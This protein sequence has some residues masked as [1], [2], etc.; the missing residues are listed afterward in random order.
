MPND[1]FDDDLDFAG[2]EGMA[3]LRKALEKANKRISELE[4]ENTTFH[5]KAREKT[6]A[7]ALATLGVN[8]K[9]AALVPADISVDG[10]AEW[11]KEYGFVAPPSGDSNETGFFSEDEQTNMKRIEGATEKAGGTPQDLAAAISAAQSR[12]ELE[13][14]LRG[15]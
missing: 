5:A 12:E 15:Q 1:G 3:N 6:V 14:I 7:E 4:D 11:A 13:A 10:I 9:I 2:S 8:E